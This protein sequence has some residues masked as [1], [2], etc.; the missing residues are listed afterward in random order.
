MD[1]PP[2][3]TADPTRRLIPRHAATTRW[4]WLRHAP[5]VGGQGRLYGADDV[6]ADVSDAAAFRALAARL[7]RGALWVTSPLLRARQTQAAVM[8]AG[9]PA[10]EVEIE[11]DFAEQDYGQWQGLDN[12]AMAEATSAFARHK[13][14]FAPADAQ[15]PGGEDFHAVMARVGRG[16]AARNAAHPGRDIVAVAHGGVIRAAIALALG[17]DPEVALGIA[18]ENL[19]TTRLDHLAGP[20][21]GGDWRLAFA[22]ARP[23]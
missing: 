10:L 3:K 9:Y 2:G 15:P 22:N 12:R 21:R 4:W 18:V 11:A 8:A 6:P 20:G 16:I 7:P 5:V 13:F 1:R 17:L 19:S 14:W 23:R